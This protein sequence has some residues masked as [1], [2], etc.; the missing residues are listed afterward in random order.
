VP[1]VPVFQNKVYATVSDAQNIITGNVKLV[2]CSNC[3]FIFNA[4]FD[5][6]VMNYDAQYQ[7]EQA[8]SHYFQRY[9][10][11]LIDL[12][13]EKRFHDMKIVEIGCGKGYFL[14][15]LMENGFDV[16]GFDPA[17]E[18]NSPYIVKDYYSDQYSHL[19]A[20]L[21]VLR[22]TLEH[23]DD[24]LK[25]LHGIARAVSYNAKIFIEVPS[26]EW[27]VEKRAFWDIFYEHC[28]YFTL[29]SLAG[30]FRES[31][32]GLL[33][34]NQYMYL[35]SDLSNLR[36]QAMPANASLSDFETSKVVELLRFYRK[37]IRS[38]PGMLVWGAGAKG[39]TF[40]R[41]T[42]PNREYISSLVDINPEKQEKYIAK[43]GHSIISPAQLAD[44]AGG[45]VL[46]MNDNYY[47]EIQEEIKG[48][49][50]NLYS[51]GEIQ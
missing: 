48:K 4:D 3:G 8:H 14:E 36:E 37:F 20:D 39:A 1:N 17:Y 13:A 5:K 44:F 33:F 23:I 10:R 50:F 43:T 24:P 40:V 19:N 25:F 29:N 12:F 28:N 41:L 34:N 42:D 18:G 26:F 38:H 6:K 22:H 51:L 9:L 30:L 16:I 49:H 31:E 7:N 27:I 46:V 21:I 15:M 2:M 32:Q 45:E 35:L 11:E 47:Q